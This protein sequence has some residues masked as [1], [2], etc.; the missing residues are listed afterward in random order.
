VMP[1]APSIRRA[2]LHPLTT[3]ETPQHPYQSCTTNPVCNP[4]RNGRILKYDHSSRSFRL[5]SARMC[6]YRRI[7]EFGR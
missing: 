4:D 5:D 3:G 2:A 1:S 6:R 7:G